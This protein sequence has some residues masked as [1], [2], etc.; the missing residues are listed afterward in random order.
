MSTGQL[1][2]AWA[3][4][5]LPAALNSGCVPPDFSSA[6]MSDKAKTSPP[7][8]TARNA[9]IGIV[10]ALLLYVLSIGPVWRL[11]KQGVLSHDFSAI[12]APIFIVC[13]YDRNISGRFIDWYSKLWVSD[14]YAQEDPLNVP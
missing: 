10:V 3:N 12:Y 5:A 6:L 11:E 2:T 8:H 14:L 9:G 13:Y 4:W 7:R 1:A